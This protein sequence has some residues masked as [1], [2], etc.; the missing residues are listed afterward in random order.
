MGWFP[1]RSW[2]CPDGAIGLEFCLA[3]AALDAS[4]VAARLHG[5]TAAPLLWL[6]LWLWRSGSP[7]YWY[8]AP[9]VPAAEQSRGRGT[10]E[11]PAAPAGR[12]AWLYSA[13]LNS[14]G[15]LPSRCH[16]RLPITRIPSPDA[17]FLD[18]PGAGQER[19]DSRTLLRT[20]ARRQEDKNS[21]A[22]FPRSVGTS[23]FGK[24]RSW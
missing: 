1:S 7:R 22:L 8:S 11:T 14:S 24:Q 18:R 17:Q 9:A 21:P 15:L 16:L 6:W 10:G 19:H 5:C 23:L 20:K 13:P 4:S 2:S 12:S 3:A